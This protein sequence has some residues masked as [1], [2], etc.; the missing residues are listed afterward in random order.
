MN[1]V[2]KKYKSEEVRFQNSLNKVNLFAVAIIFFTIVTAYNSPLSTPYIFFTMLPL[3]ILQ[4]YS[5]AIYYNYLK[6]LKKLRCMEAGI[7]CNDFSIPRSASVGMAVKSSFLIIF[8]CFDFAWLFSAYIIPSTANS[9]QEYLNRLQVGFISGNAFLIF[10]ALFWITYI[11]LY[12]IGIY[13]EKELK[14]S[15]HNIESGYIQRVDFLLN[16][17]TYRNEIVK[18]NGFRIPNFSKQPLILLPGFSQNGNVYDMLPGNG[19][20]AEFLWYRGYDVWIIHPRGTGGSGVSKH[21]NSLDDYSCDDIPSIINFVFES[22][23]IKPLLVGHSQGG[24]TSLMSLMGVI[25]TKEGKA[26]LSKDE[27]LSR[28][29]ILKGL[30]TLGSFP[31]FKFSKESSLQK[32]VNDGINIKWL[33]ITIRSQKILNALKIFKRLPVPMG[34]RYRRALLSQNGLTIISF[35][36]KKILNIFGQLDFWEFLYHIPNVSDISRKYLFYLTIDG[37]FWKILKQYY[38]AVRA[39]GMESIDKEIKYFQN[40]NLINL[41]V[42]FVG[43]EYDSMAN[44]PMIK[45]MLLTKVSSK[46]KYFTEWKGQGHEDFFMNS[47]YFKQVFD[48]INLIDKRE[49]KISDDSVANLLAFC[50]ERNPEL[51][52]FIDENSYMNQKTGLLKQTLPLPTL[53]V[54]FNS[55]GEEIFV[56]SDLHI[57]SGKNSNGVYRGT[58]NFFADES[59]SN[60]LKY[61]D[62]NKK[63]DSAILIING[64]VFDFLRVLEYP[65]RVREI[66]FSKWAKEAIKLN[67]VKEPEKPTPKDIEC[68][69][70]EWQKELEKVGIKKSINELEESISDI[71]KSVGLKTNDY[72]SVLK[73]NI[74]NK[75]HSTFFNALAEWM[76]SNNKIFII[77][78]NHDTEWY[79]PAVRNYFRL[80][81]GERIA[82]KHS[83]DLEKT[84]NTTV[85]PNIMFYDD[86]VVIDKDFYVEHGHRYDK[87]TM[88]L[89]DPSVERYPDQ[90]NIPFGSFFN[91]YLLNRIELFY[92]FID[93][94]R[95]SGNLLPILMR[96]NFPLGLKVLF[97]HVP[98]TMRVIFF[99]NFRYIRFMFN[100]VFWFILVLVLPVILAIYFNFGQLK[101]IFFPGNQN[102]KSIGS[103]LFDQLIGVGALFFS[104]VLTRIVSWFQLNEPSSLDKYAKV[105][106]EKNNYKIMTMGH[107]HNPGQYCYN[108]DGEKKLFYNTGTW[109]PVIENSN[110]EVRND[111]IFTFLHLDRNIDNSLKVSGSG[112]LLRWNDDALRAEPQILV[113][114]K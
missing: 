44:P 40:Y 70:E 21:S 32:F 63:S 43:M 104:Y 64:D 65:G 45:D 81:I 68:K 6:S 113:E 1:I 59:F 13:F 107:T 56:V 46:D 100:K 94:V 5:A 77:K 98:L 53:P 61:A 7:Y 11:F 105:W 52:Y 60:F 89:K 36:V 23:K 35:P 19:S 90:L 82:A 67:P 58:E 9:F 75:G 54:E 24:I 41:P 101:E 38:D 83:S 47:K 26:V 15:K 14:A 99:T 73:L 111:K 48:A 42:S 114:R 96:E 93:N 39:G 33:N 10:T 110:A 92:P 29:S 76:M 97:Q 106:L 80:I 2:Q 103:I 87:F 66:R 37:T 27:S 50:E 12:N 95:P 72:K 34:N 49:E 78:G 57:A 85:I 102:P 30:V 17:V 22:T 74:I 20:L 55:N 18:L 86:A 91:R 25:K 4:F 16:V 62:E 3:L 112:V 69:F 31:D 88:I 51:K 79:W 71:E 84:L 108:F 109:I 28:Q 8:L